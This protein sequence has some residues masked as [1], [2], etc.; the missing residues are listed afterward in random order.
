MP[1]SNHG[2]GETLLVANFEGNRGKDKCLV[3]F[4]AGPAGTSGGERLPGV[5]NLWI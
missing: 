1:P 3:S 4:L 5:W 2:K